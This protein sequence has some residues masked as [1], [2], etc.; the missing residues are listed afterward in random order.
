MIAYRLF[1]TVSKQIILKNFVIYELHLQGDTSSQV[2]IFIY[3]V[4]KTFLSDR[5]IR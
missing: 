4:T 1:F 3:T 5:I 2:F